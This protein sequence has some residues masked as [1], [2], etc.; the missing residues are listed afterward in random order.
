MPR[1]CNLQHGC[2]SMYPL[3]TMACKLMYDAYTS[4]VFIGPYIIPA[5]KP[6]CSLCIY[7]WVHLYAS[8]LPCIHHLERIYLRVYICGVL[9]IPGPVNLQGSI[10]LPPVCAR[11]SLTDTATEE[12]MLFLSSSLADF[13]LSIAPSRNIE[14]HSIPCISIISLNLGYLKN[15]QMKLT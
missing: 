8:C 10:A 9:T 11:T 4:L 13:S 7:D 12:R 1:A 3:Y 5:Y 15:R 6:T 2:L 14:N